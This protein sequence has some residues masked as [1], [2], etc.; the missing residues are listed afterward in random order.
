LEKLQGQFDFEVLDARGD[1]TR[2]WQWCDQDQLEQLGLLTQAPTKPFENYDRIDVPATEKGV[3]TMLAAARVDFTEFNIKR[4]MESVLWRLLR[5]ECFF[6]AWPDGS[7]VL[8]MIETVRI[9]WVHNG[10]VLV[11]E[12]DHT[13]LGARQ[14]LPGIEKPG[15]EAPTAAAKR[16]WTVVLKMP[17]DTGNFIEDSMEDRE[18]VGYKGLRCVERSH[19]IEVTLDTD[20]AKVLEKVGLPGHSGFRIIDPQDEEAGSDVVRKFKWMPQEECKECGVIQCDFETAETFEVHTSSKKARFC[21]SK[22]DRTERLRKFLIMN[23]ADPDSWDGDRDDES[24]PTLVALSRE[25]SSGKCILTKNSQGLQRCVNVV[26]LRLWSPDR[27]LML[28]HKGSKYDD[29]SEKW[30]AQLPGAKK[31]GNETVMD[32]CRHICG[33]ELGFTEEEVNFPDEST[34]E[35]FDYTAKSRGYEG[36]VTKY[37]K[38]FVDV[39]LEDDEDLWTRVGLTGRVESLR[40]ED[41]EASVSPGM[42]SMGL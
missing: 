21:D 9:R 31:D 16:M 13:F 19:V 5:A 15:S 11:Q 35:V 29:D 27:K 41:M 38:F 2:R 10:R 34:W 36:L 32:T 26:V 1:K 12:K 25:L 18:L 17:A 39:V 20:D 7:K 30:N 28:V 6:M 33:V 4:D 40:P 8:L 42:F 24:K 23:G 3:E 14:S 37:Q 22:L